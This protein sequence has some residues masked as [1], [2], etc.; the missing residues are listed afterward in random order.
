MSFVQLVKR[1]FSDVRRPR[2]EEPVFEFDLADQE[3]IVGTFHYW[4]TDYADRATV[5][6]HIAVWV[7]VRL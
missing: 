5:D 2:G 3:E 1:T 4:T 7:A 6:H